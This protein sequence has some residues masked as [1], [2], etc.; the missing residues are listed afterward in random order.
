MNAAAQVIDELI[1]ANT[2]CV[3]CT[4]MPD[5]SP[6]ASAAHFATVDHTQMLF[7]SLHRRSRTAEN[8]IL[9]SRTAITIGVDPGVPA[10]LQMRGHTTVSQGADLEI[11]QQTFYSRFPRSSRYKDDPRTLFVCFRPAWSRYS[12]AAARPEF[13]VRGFPASS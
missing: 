5:G 8:I 9:D 13:F 6:H 1:T 12:D 4:L 11:A 2:I 3:V 7:L 10:T